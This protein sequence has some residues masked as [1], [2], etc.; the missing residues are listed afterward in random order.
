MPIWENTGVLGKKGRGKV[1]QSRSTYYDIDK[2]LQ[3]V[4]RAYIDL[5]TTA[6]IFHYLDRE[7]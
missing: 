1:N 5:A 7:R 2:D 3:Y 4:Y 6:V